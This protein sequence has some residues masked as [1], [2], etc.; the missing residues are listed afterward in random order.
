MGGIRGG[1]G[2]DLLQLY[3]G[4][5]FGGGGSRPVAT[6]WGGGLW[7]RGSRPVATVCIIIKAIKYVEIYRILK[8]FFE[9]Q[10]IHT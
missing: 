10:Y 4:G 8:N 6:V 9:K 5:G 3:G 7:G 2:A 1:G